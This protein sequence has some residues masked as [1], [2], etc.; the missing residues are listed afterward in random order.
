MECEEKRTI[1][2]VDDSFTDRTLLRK[3]F[4]EEF[5]VVQAENGMKALERLYC[6]PEISAVVLDIQMPELDGYGVLEAMRADERLREIPVVVD[7][8]SDETESQLK[9]LDYGAVDVLIKPFNP[10]VAQRRIH[11]IIARREAE[12]HALRS[13]LLEE[14]LRR[15]EI[16]EKTGIYNKQGFCRASAEMMQSNPDK[17][18]IILRWD[19]D[20]FKVF[21]DIYGVAAG[22][23]F[24]ARIGEECGKRIKGDVVFGR[25]N[26]DHFVICMESDS[27]MANN[28]A[29]QLI[30]M[31]AGIHESF[32]FAARI[33]V[34]MVDD[35]Y[36]EVSL[37]CDRAKLALRSIKNKY[38]AR[39]AYYD[40]SMRLAL[41]EEQDIVGDMKAALERG[42]FVVYLQPQ[43]NYDTKT[44]HGAEALVRWKHPT[45][46]MIPPGRFIP[47]FER[48]GFIGELDA[49]VWE[50]VCKFQRGWLDAG[51]AAVPISVNVS[52]C[53]VYNHRLCEFLDGLVK[54]YGLDHSMLHLEITETAYMDDPEQL[55][56]VVR[57]LRE[58]GFSVEM[59]D[60][61]SGYSSL[62]TLKDVPVDMLKLDMKFLGT[63]TDDTRSGSILTSVIR[64]AHW[65]KLP[66]LAEGVETKEQAEYL[67]SVGCI[68]MQGYY[69]ARPMPKKQ[70]EEILRSTALEEPNEN[71]FSS[72]VEGSMDFLSAATQSTLLF[73][74]FVGGALIVEFDGE[75]V[76]ALRMN[77][78]YFETLGIGREEYGDAHLH[79]QERFYKPSRERFIKHLR[80]A[81]R[82]GKETGC[83]VCSMPLRQGGEYFWTC[84]R[85]RLLAKNGEKYILYIS[86]ENA[87]KQKKLLAKVLRLSRKLTGILDNLPDGVLDWAITD[88][89]Q[90]TYFNDRAANMFGYDREEYEQLY[91]QTP[92]AA[93]HPENRAQM[94]RFI[95]EIRGGREADFET[96]YRHACADG[97]WRWTKLKVHAIHKEDQTFFVSGIQTD[98]DAQLRA[99]R[100]DP[101]S[102]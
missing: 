12:Q 75:N 55:I 60:F 8:A 90:N 41:I 44:L 86:I 50:E 43:Y 39:V 98:V 97:S 26:A 3:T 9:A 94:E 34:Y 89:V 10:K 57:R 83:E 4:E 21:N 6:M 29:E 79:I 30:D 101:T 14:Q 68:Y 96:L 48:N 51:M 1:L 25:W 88:S 77:D 33:G 56:R 64:M 63:G 69:C 99:A 53:D 46:G 17:Q 28:I 62:N 66:V 74:S 73:N 87:N 91:A 24:L 11:N 82:T 84:N 38:S 15:S 16:D 59:D 7:T 100:N 45:K 72:D 19:V 37:M 93:V 85:M 80:E 13:A 32:V 81:V 65:L 40:D 20:R 47:V 71:C 102:A 49:F 2:V 5:H 52:R 92:L 58:I 22:D 35:P 67:K 31:V 27:F 18:Y 76:E 54:K 42:D 61:G 70:F 78:K 95:E 36:C 23:W